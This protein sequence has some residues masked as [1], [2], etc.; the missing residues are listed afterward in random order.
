MNNH[1]VDRFADA[2][3]EIKSLIDDLEEFKETM[4]WA[5]ET[6][7]S[8][9]ISEPRM[10]LFSTG[11][12]ERR[13]EL[14]K[15]ALDVFIRR[16]LLDIYE[17]NLGESGYLLGYTLVLRDERV[18]KT[19][20]RLSQEKDLWKKLETPSIPNT[21]LEKKVSKY[22]LNE[23]EIDLERKL[24]VNKNNQQKR[25]FGASTAFYLLKYLIEKRSFCTYEELAEELKGKKSAKSYSSKELLDIKSRLIINLHENLHISRETAESLISSN[26]GFIIS[27]Y[28]EEDTSV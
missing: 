25:K 16:R 3:G 13:A 9:P 8:L 11:Y 27:Q 17:A 1:F 26:D 12:T 19:F 14:K 15:I 7:S 5:V 23:L 10:V 22:V 4:L 21:N 24:F 20:T 28:L 2:V 18:E 6:L